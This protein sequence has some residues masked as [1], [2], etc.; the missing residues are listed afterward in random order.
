M[1]LFSIEQTDFSHTHTFIFSSQIFNR[2]FYFEKND[3]INSS[4]SN[5]YLV[6]CISVGL[7]ST[8]PYMNCYTECPLVASVQIREKGKFHYHQRHSMLMV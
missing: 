5:R 6:I 1:P 7:D 3:N 8:Y 4:C 2:F